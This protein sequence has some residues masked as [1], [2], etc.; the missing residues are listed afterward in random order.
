M[1]RRANADVLGYFP[2][3]MTTGES[4]AENESTVSNEEFGKFLESMGGRILNRM[5][6]PQE[7]ASVRIRFFPRYPFFLTAQSSPSMGIAQRATIKDITLT[8]LLLRSC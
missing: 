7:L 4:N 2:S 1:D 3:E 8:D 5:G 6:T